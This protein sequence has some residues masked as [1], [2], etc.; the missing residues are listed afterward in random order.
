MSG[1]IIC[2]LLCGII[3]LHIL[4][5]FDFFPCLHALLGTAYL[6]NFAEKFLHAGLFGTRNSL[7]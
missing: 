1:K 2:T 7:F 3:M 5:I 6:F 4:L